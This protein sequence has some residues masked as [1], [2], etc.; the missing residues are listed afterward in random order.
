MSNI[1][2]K[3][4]YKDLK[5]YHVVSNSQLTFA[6]LVKELAPKIKEQGESADENL[7]EC[8]DP[9]QFS[10]VGSDQV[11]SLLSNNSQITL[12]AKL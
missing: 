1:R 4:Q 9:D 11:M 5:F 12:K 7:L 10:Y 6:E 8:C 3:V 2:L